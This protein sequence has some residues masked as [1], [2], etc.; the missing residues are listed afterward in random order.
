MKNY[1]LFFVKKIDKDFDIKLSDFKEVV[2]DF[3]GE[4]SFFVFR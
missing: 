3:K 1:I 2:K 4:V